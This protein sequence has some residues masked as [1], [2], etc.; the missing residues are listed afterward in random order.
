M[1]SSAFCI[2]FWIKER[3]I[4][5]GFTFSNELISTDEGLHRDFACLMYSMIVHKPPEDQILAIIEEAV[6]FQ[7]D[8]VKEM[9]EVPL[10]NMNVDLMNQYVKY[11]ADNLSNALSMPKI[12]EVALPFSFME[13]ISFNGQ[14]NF[15]ERRVGEYSLG[16]FETEDH[17]NEIV[18]DDEY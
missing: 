8:F 2:I 4:L 10:T 6:A 1:F 13:N 5:P 12:Y 18:L 11:T 17:D 7:E 14:T 3:G 15:F 9:L 16:G